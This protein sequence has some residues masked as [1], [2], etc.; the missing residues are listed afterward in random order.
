MRSSS[1]RV[2][3]AASLLFRF[4]SACSGAANVDRTVLTHN[5]LYG[6]LAQHY[7]RPPTKLTS[8]EPTRSGSNRS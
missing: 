6:E 5:D 4:A 7:I 2:I 8:Q 3:A 1:V